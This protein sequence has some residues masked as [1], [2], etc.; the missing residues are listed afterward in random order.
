MVKSHN[1]TDIKQSHRH[2]DQSNTHYTLQLTAFSRC[3]LASATQ[4]VCCVSSS[5]SRSLTVA[6]RRGAGL[7]ER[8]A[9]RHR[10]ASLTRTGCWERKNSPMAR[11]A[12]MVGLGG[13]VQHNTCIKY[14]TTEILT[15]RQLGHSLSRSCI[16]GTN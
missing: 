7:S 8:T 3:S 15:H 6:S 1:Q 4:W 2:T 10:V 5:P 11:R 9:M 16:L 12:D 14:T 13:R